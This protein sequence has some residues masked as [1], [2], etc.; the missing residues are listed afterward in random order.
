LSKLSYKTVA[1]RLAP[2]QKF[3]AL[4]YQFFAFLWQLPTTNLKKIKAL[5]KYEIDKLIHNKNHLKKA[6]FP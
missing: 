5:L 4:I 1:T 6:A 3:E 2:T